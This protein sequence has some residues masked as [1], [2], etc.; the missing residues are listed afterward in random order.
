MSESL[1]GFS[2]AATRQNAGSAAYCC[3]ALPR[4]APPGGTNAPAAML[5]ADVTVA[6]C[7]DR[8][9]RLSHDPPAASAVSARLKSR[10]TDK[11]MRTAPVSNV[12]LVTF[13]ISHSK[14][15][16]GRLTVDV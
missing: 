5:V 16:G 1:E 6:F 7:S 9:T 4:P 11:Q 10:P 12:S 2:V 14:S 3:T 15:G 13:F 8:P